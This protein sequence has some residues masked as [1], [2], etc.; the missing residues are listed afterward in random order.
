MPLARALDDT[1]TPAIKEN[2]TLLTT[3]KLLTTGAYRFVIPFLAVL[4]HGLHIRIAQL[5]IALTVS[6]LTGLLGP[7]VGRHVDRGSHRTLM[8]VSTVGMA[9]GALTCALARGIVAF[10]AGIFVI[11]VFKLLFD[12]AVTGWIAEHVP[13]EGRG[14]VLGIIE[15]SWAGG[16]FIGVALLGAVTAIWSWRWAYAFASLA[17]VGAAV[18]TLVRL[19]EGRVRADAPAAHER[20]RRARPSRQA[21]SFLLPMMFLLLSIEMIVVVLGPWLQDEHGFT[22]GGITGIAFGLGVFELV[23][24]IAATRLTDRLG[25]WRSVMRGGALMFPAAI[26]FV[27]GHHVLALGLVALALATLGFE[28]AIISS[29]SVATSLVP[30]APA[31]GLGLM[32]SINTIGR[33]AGTALSTWMYDHHGPTVA[34][35]PVIGTTIVATVAL[36]VGLS[37]RDRRERAA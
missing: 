34:V 4:A 15:M 29:M 35:S 22:S 32:I 24:S 8:V 10:G 37:S 7:V 13:A 36:A 1:Y 12:I 9:G 17:L 21:W 18:L 20:V 11:A 25:G 6:E 30:G 16:L 28:F 5:G 14:R 3:T 26:I 31:A 23:S 2:I 33:S 27:V 19:P